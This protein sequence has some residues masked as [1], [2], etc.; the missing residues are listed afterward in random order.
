MDNH[1]GVFP[2]HRSVRFLLLTATS[3]AAT[4]QIVCR[5][6]LDD[7]ARLES[8]GRDPADPFIG[9]AVRLTPATLERISGE[10]LSIPNLR[11]PMDL[12]I[13]ERA[14]ALFPPLGSSAG[15]NAHFG[16]ELNATDDRGAFRTDGRGLP[17]VDGRHIEPFHVAVGASGRSITAAD[18]RRL[19]R[20]NGHEHPR[21]AYRDVASATNRVT[22][23]A[24]VLPAGC[25]STHTI[26]CLR[27]P[28]PRAAHDFLCGMFNS[29]VVNY[30]VRLRVTTHVSTATVEL[31]PVPTA[32]IAPAAL[33]EI[34][35]FARRLAR[36]YDAHA[37]AHLNARVAMLYQLGV[38]EFEYV[39]STFPLVE[40][41]VREGCLDVFKRA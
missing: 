25:V 19:L 5:L 4:R 39:L 1:R 13:V 33:G 14:A 11:T 34:A 21:L 7:P 32:E 41:S 12:A 28:V 24:A 35:V 2:I 8:I 40:R 36:R 23:I 15:W 18:A 31:L 17:I 10:S 29:F 37:I 3:G 38:G 30:L 9:V 27:T 20:S 6:G 16:R 26:F 22:L